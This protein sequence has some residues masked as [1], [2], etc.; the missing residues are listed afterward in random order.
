VINIEKIKVVGFDLDKTLYPQSDD[1][2]REIKSYI[3]QKIDEHLKCGLDV[4]RELFND[5]YQ[6]GKGSSVSQALNTLK[7]PDAKNIVQKALEN[8]NFS[9]YLKPNE[10]DLNTLY[11]IKEKYKN[12]D[13][14]TGSVRENALEK[15]NSLE[16]NQ[17][18]FNNKFFGDDASKSD[19]EMYRMWMDCYEFQPENFMNVGDREFSDCLVPQKL[20]IS[21]ILVNQEKEDLEHV[22]P[23]L[24]RFV[25]L[26]NILL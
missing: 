20:G 21:S 25:D 14:L 2:D 8:A 16:I 6:E 7:V 13:L 10:V 5:I 26:E 9:K 1:I 4:A 19:G 17:D 15:L 12:I 23:K 3:F 24:K 22:F 11:K 18:I